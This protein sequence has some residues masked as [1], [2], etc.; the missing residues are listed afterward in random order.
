[1]SPGS[2]HGCCCK[3]LG[4]RSGHVCEKGKRTRPCSMAS[5]PHEGEAPLPVAVA[6]EGRGFLPAGMRVPLPR[7]LGWLEPSRSAVH[8]PP[9]P[10]I[11][12]PPPRTS[13]FIV[14]GA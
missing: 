11:H 12:T 8:Q 10:E 9:H 13:R 6:L 3:L 7:F 4:L 14:S 5:H 2:A 1:M